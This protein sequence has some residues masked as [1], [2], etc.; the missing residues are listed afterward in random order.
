MSEPLPDTDLDNPSDRLDAGLA[1]AFGPDSGAHT[2]SVSLRDPLSEDSGPPSSPE[3]PPSGI[4]GRNLL[5]GEIGHGGMGAVFRGRDPALGRELAVKVLLETHRDHPELVQRFLEEAQIGG[6]LQ[7]PGI[8]PVYELGRFADDRP[9][10]TMKLVKGQTLAKLLAQSTSPTDELPRF[11]GIFEQV[12]QTMAYAHARGV[13]H[14]D[15]KPA[16]IMV[17]SFGEVQVMDW[18]MAKV[19]PTA[20]A[21]GESPPTPGEGT[22]IKTVRSGSGAELSQAGTAL[23]TP[24]F[25]PPEQA[26]GEVGRIDER[27]DVFG[28]GAILCVLLTEKPP[29]VGR[30]KGE[31][32][33]QAIRGDLADARARL[34]DCGREVELV[35]LCKECLAPERDN[36]LRDAGVVAQRISAYQAG[37]QQR[38]R[39]AELERAAAQARTEEAKATAAAEQARAAEEARGRKLAMA[40]AE[41]AKAKAAAERR[42]RQRA[43]GLAAAV[44]ALVAGGALGGL[45]LQRQ[46][47]QQRTELALQE[48]ERR[49]DAEVELEKAIGFQERARWAEARLVLEQAR[50]RLGD[51]APEELR[52]RLERA[53]SDLALVARLDVIRQKWILEKGKT[54]DVSA[55]RDYPAAFRETGLGQVGDDATAVADRIRGSAIR[56]QLVAALDAWAIIAKKEDQEWL[57]A[58]ARRADPDPW[59]DRF[60]DPAVWGDRAALE[61]LAKELLRDETQLAKQQPQLL[62]ALAFALG[63][64]KGDVGPLLTAAQ[65]CYRSDFWLSLALGSHLF[66]AQK[67]EEAIGYFR[68][69]LAVQPESV[70][71]RIILGHALEFK[72]QLNEA[73]KEY[74]AA[75]AVD[76]KDALARFFL[77]HTLEAEGQLDEAI[78]EYR[79]AIRLDPKFVAAHHIL[80]FA[81]QTKGQLDEAIHEYRTAIDL[82]AKYAPVHNNLGIALQAKGQ[83][84]EAI[85]EYRAVLA[86]E[87][88]HP[89]AKENL[90]RAER[91]LLRL[92]SKLPPIMDGKEEPA[93]AAESLALA[94]LCQEPF[95]KLYAAAARFYFQSFAQG[96][97]LA[98]DVQKWHRYSAAGVAALAGC[99]QGKDADKLDDKER[100]RLRKQAL[101][102]LKA[103]LAHWTKQAESDQ[104]QAVQQTM[105]HWQADADFT[106]VRNPDALAKLP[107]EE[108][109]AWQQLWDDVAAVLKKAESKK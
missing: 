6:Q 43:I 34:D 20:D 106:G 26:N 29:Y 44:L 97:Q 46:A 25:M 19:L 109:A 59:R 74:R 37:V 22:V 86:L 73:M 11:L 107:A 27:A 95:K 24:A 104:P 10:F 79:E 38:L 17:G 88:K 100:A 60:R 14:R 53:L 108:R 65:R 70:V 67:W 4:A 49:H 54:G 55:L 47:E 30:D 50:E 85:R 13:I 28:L 92:E 8:V 57:L 94:Q 51:A 68:T 63:Q 102:W 18:G 23:G 99:G 52:K 9:F 105:K 82:D 42:A 45:Y 40:L 81:L 64:A 7:H 76:P 91:R 96:A 36:R 84:D 5:F 16:N 77:G 62:V 56:V 98:D 87:P 32:L 93:D 66:V 39:E 103:D 72:G 1:A 35:R 83:L 3:L 71:A 80:G 2:G 69:G 41:E 89:I 12:C 48:A 78:R 58:V 61:A 31:L 75:V 101:E 90:A 33:R 21:K 15:L